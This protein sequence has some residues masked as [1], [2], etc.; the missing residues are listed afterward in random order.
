MGTIG[1]PQM[2]V[3]NYHYLLHNN[4]EECSLQVFILFENVKFWYDNFTLPGIS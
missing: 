3:R 4:P 2:S 1:C